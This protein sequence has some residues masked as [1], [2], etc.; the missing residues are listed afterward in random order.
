MATWRVKTCC[1]TVPFA[2]VTFSTT[3][4]TFKVKSDGS[5][6]GTSVG[7]PVGGFEG[8]DDGDELGSI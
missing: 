7:C 6:D 4:V 5:R 2:M 3:S 1:F 8:I